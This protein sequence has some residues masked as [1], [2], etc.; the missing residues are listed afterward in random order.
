VIVGA[1]PALGGEIWETVPAGVQWRLITLQAGLVTDLTVIDRTVS[2]VLDDGANVFLQVGSSYIQVASQ[3]MW[4]AFGAFSRQGDSLG[5]AI[6]CGYPEGIVLGPGFRFRTFTS[7]I[8]AGDNWGAPTY[9]VEE[10]PA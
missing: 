8:Q 6:L 10:W 3:F 1:D 4:Y 5:G 7:G 2:L 9:M